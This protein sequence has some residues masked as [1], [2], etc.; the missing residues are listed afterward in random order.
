MQQAQTER[1]RALDQLNELRQWVAWDWVHRPGKEPAKA[2]VTPHTWQPASTSDPTTWGTYEQAVQAATE[3]ERGFLRVGFV[4]SPE[5][6][7][8]GIDPYLI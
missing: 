8:C 1:H 4:F 6:E 5:D 3:D 2:P 7:Y